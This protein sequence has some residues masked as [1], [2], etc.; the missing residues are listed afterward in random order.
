MHS[1]ADSTPDRRLFRKF[2]TFAIATTLAGSASA[3]LNDDLIDAHLL[4][5]GGRVAQDT[6]GFTREDGETGTGSN[7]NGTNG[8]TAWF[9]WTAPSG[10]P[11]QVRFSTYGSNY[12]T[13]I[14]LF[15]QNP[16]NPTPLVTS[17]LAVTAPENPVLVD[18]DATI[19]VAQ[20]Y[21]TWAPIA[22]TT[23]YISVG[24]NGNANNNS[25]L[26]A[27]FAGVVAT[28]GMTPL[29]V[30]DPFAGALEFAAAPV[31]GQIP[32][33]QAV[34]GTTIG[35][36]AET[37]ELAIDNAPNPRGGTVWYKYRTGPTAEKFSVEINGIPNETKGEV[38][39]QQFRN[40]VL[41]VPTFLQLDYQGDDD[42]SSLTGTPRLMVDGD[43]NTE[44]YFRVTSNG[45]GTTGDGVNFNIRLDFNPTAP[46]NDLIAAAAPLTSA[47]P[48]VRNIGED[49]YSATTTDSFTGNTSGNNIWYSWK[50]PFTGSVRLRSIA[51]TPSA[52]TG[53]FTTASSFRYDCEVYFDTTNP[54]DTVFDTVARQEVANFDDGDSPQQLSFYAIKDVVYYIEVGG[55]NDDDA[56]GRGFV[57]FVIEEN[58]LTEAARTGV[59]YGEEGVLK[60][61][62]LPV[63]NRQGDIAFPSTFEL[64]GPIAANNDSGLFL[65]TSN[66]TRVVATEGSEEYDGTALFGSFSNLFLADRTNN[67][68]LNPDLGFNAT[69]TGEIDDKPVTSKNN[70][71]FYHDDPTN[72]GVTEFRLNDY[73]DDSQT[74][75]DGGGF[76]AAF[77]TPVRKTTDN[78]ALVTGRM[79]A[80]PKIRDTAIFA[81]T[82]NIVLQEE[83]PAPGTVDGVEFGDITGIPSVNSSNA[84]AFRAVLRGTDVTATNDT[85]IY[86]VA[87]FRVDLNAL[88]Y[89]LRLREGSPVGTTIAGGATLLSVGE[90]RINTRG[91]IATLVGFKP[92][93]GSPA[94]AKTNDTAIVSDLLTS[95][96]SFAIVAR[97]GDEARDSN[98]AVMTGVRFASFAAPVL[99][100][101]NAVIFTAKLAG[102]G[103]NASN[104]LGIW[105]WDGAAVYQVAREGQEAPGVVTAGP[106][107]K[108]LGVPLANP[109]GRVA[110]TATL[111]GA[112]VTAANDSGLWTVSDDAITPT[113]RLRKGDVYD[114]GRT[115]LP[116]R[117]TITSI[118][119][120]TG[121]GG[122]D[123]FARGMD[124][125]GGVAV[126]VDLS[127]GKAKAGQAAFKVAP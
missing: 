127:K 81:T 51:P 40:T 25:Q 27:S 104:D 14:K 18:D 33:G 34:P 85:A 39:I 58:R 118:S 50:A 66:T 114:F 125:D 69:L 7:N 17:L 29:I 43:A 107:F 3:A 21:V 87:D 4:D 100:S 72:D 11:A 99:I 89:R 8:R 42:N 28:D 38:T 54:T 41:T 101:N 36:T 45:P 19:N 61:I 91:K 49:I 121:S 74:W 76:L 126:V 67:N 32:R 115:E 95:D 1:R 96:F 80:I 62:G 26:E 84:M 55:D 124:Q 15:K 2:A 88:N 46:A 82:R 44:Y 116:F 31:A 65:Y 16:A 23:Y 117:R 60:T 63:V 5:L 122:D 56:A 108:S 75:G 94:V 53:N 103:V 35:A 83:D 24:R 109:S 73:A 120:T 57:A 90:P 93:T 59:S 47:L 64:G 10:G 70:R 37:G 102:T 97:E 78:I 86:T 112:G 123:G 105:L 52:G 111:A 48:S 30:N 119:V 6:A 12:D 9:A 106:T 110:F 22:G 13:V 98:G 113:L 79:V 20:G 92:G 71:G 77:N 68:D